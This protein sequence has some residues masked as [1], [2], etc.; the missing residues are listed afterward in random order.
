MM[1]GLSPS[2]LQQLEAAGFYVFR[3]PPPGAPAA[4]LKVRAGRAAT[5]GDQTAPQRPTP[6]AAAGRSAD[7][8]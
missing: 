8:A 3:D 4:P 6:G 7:H 2:L 5:R 1:T